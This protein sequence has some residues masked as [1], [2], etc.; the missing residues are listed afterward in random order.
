MRKRV[1][2]CALLFILSVAM[3][4]PVQ[5]EAE[6]VRYVALGDSLAAG[7]TPNR[8]IGVSYTD[9]IAMALQQNGQLESFSKSLAFPGYTTEQVLEQL[10]TREARSLIQRADLITIS[11]GA[12]DLLPL[13]QNDTVRGMLSY[14]AIPVA[15]RLNTVRKNYIKLF[16]EIKEINPRADVYAMGYYFPYPHVK[17]MQKPA[18]AGQ[19]DILN[20]IIEQ[21]AG[22]AG[23]EFVPVAH[24]FGVNADSLIPNAADVHPAPA[25]YLSM[26]NLFLQEYAPG[27]P[28][29]PDSILEQLPEPISIAELRQARER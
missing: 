20:Q 5:A 15:F 13:I 24:Y 16:K 25:G 29:L 8:E 22:R 23:A 14:E 11:A 19:L 3:L 12:N 28:L 2:S 10:N 27:A 18:V 4:S 1:F 7:Q 26:A 17:S 9:L 21:E 6:G